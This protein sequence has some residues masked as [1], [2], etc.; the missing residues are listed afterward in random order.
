MF[1]ILYLAGYYICKTMSRRPNTSRRFTDSAGI[2]FMGALHHKSRPSPLLSIGLVVVV[3][4]EPFFN[5]CISHTHIYW[6]ACCSHMNSARAL[7]GAPSLLAYC[8]FSYCH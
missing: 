3:I 7:K 6:V 1:S 5:S 4:T 8:T 2:P